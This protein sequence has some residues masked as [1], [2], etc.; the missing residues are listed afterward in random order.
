MWAWRLGRLGWNMGGE[1]GRKGGNKCQSRKG[2]V[3]RYEV[4]SREKVKA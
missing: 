1:R 4:E 2:R 3:L